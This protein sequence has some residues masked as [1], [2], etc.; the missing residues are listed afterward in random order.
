MRESIIPISL[1]VRGHAIVESLSGTALQ[2]VYALGIG[3]DQIGAVG[4]CGVVD[5]DECDDYY[6]YLIDGPHPKV[7]ESLL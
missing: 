5:V 6:L 1:S 7:I 4:L 3:M 2:K